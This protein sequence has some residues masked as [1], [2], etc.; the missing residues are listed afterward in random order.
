MVSIVSLGEKE[1]YTQEKRKVI[2]EKQQDK[3]EVQRSPETVGGNERGVT[4]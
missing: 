4:N 1:R 2:I 3:S